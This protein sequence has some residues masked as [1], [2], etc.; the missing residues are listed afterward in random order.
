MKKI[1]LAA[2]FAGFAGSAFAGAPS[3]PQVEAPVIVEEASSSSAGIL[4]P[5]LLVAVLIAAAD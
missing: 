4:L 3:E 1:V 5:L 2:A